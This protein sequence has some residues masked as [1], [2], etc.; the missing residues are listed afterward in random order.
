VSNSHN[1]FSVDLSSLSNGVYLLSVSLESGI[2]SRL[3]M[4]NRN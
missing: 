3:F 1:G 2:Q 4:V